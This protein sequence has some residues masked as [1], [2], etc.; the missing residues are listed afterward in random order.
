MLKKKKKGE[1][2]EKE[3]ENTRDKHFSRFFPLSLISKMFTD[4][5][6]SDKMPRKD[7]DLFFFCDQLLLHFLFVCSTSQLPCSLVFQHIQLRYFVFS[8]FIAWSS[9]FSYSIQ[10]RVLATGSFLEKFAPLFEPANHVGV[11]M[12]SR[13]SS[14][15]G[16]RTPFQAFLYYVI[17]T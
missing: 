8:F 12:K 5:I 10:Q 4:T 17:H 16:S 3:E 2:K 11:E 6:C 7:S 1:E 14:E 9:F 13:Q 15:A